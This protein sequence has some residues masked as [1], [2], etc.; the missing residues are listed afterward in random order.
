VDRRTAIQQKEICFLLVRLKKKKSR[1]RF[2][3]SSQANGERSVHFTQA[4]VF[5]VICTSKPFQGQTS[6]IKFTESRCNQSIST[7]LLATVKE[8]FQ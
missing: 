7:V 1:L 3:C 6:Q 5:S 2:S 8:A 4:I